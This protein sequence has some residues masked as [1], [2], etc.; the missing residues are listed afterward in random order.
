MWWLG[1]SGLSQT[2]FDGH[3]FNGENVANS[4][5]SHNW[6]VAEYKIYAYP[7]VFPLVRFAFNSFHPLFCIAL[8]KKRHSYINTFSAANIY[9][10]FCDRRNRVPGDKLYLY[11]RYR[12]SKSITWIFYPHKLIFVILIACDDNLFSRSKPFRAG[13]IPRKPHR[14]L[15]E[16]A[17]DYFY[18]I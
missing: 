10:Y 15:P 11:G 6:S 2:V 8:N 17:S 12:A 14:S 4:F 9:I 3:S 7:F 1:W 16:N 18:S 13:F 5:L